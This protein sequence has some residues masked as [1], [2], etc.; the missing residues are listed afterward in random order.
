MTELLFFL[1]AVIYNAAAI[2]LV[3]LGMLVSVRFTGFAD[4][5]VDG[6]YTLSA[7]LFCLMILYTENFWISMAVAAVTGALTG[8]ATGFVNQV[9][10]VG[11][12]ISGVIIMILAVLVSPWIVGSSSL[13]IISITGIFGVPWSDL[14]LSKSLFPDATYIIH[15]IE[16]S[17]QIICILATVIGLL[18]FLR[19]KPGVRLRYAGSAETPV[20]LTPA[21]KTLLTIAGLSLGNALVGMGAA[22]EATKIGLYH[23]NIGT[24]IIL[25]ALSVLILGESIGRAI[26]RRRIL[27][28]TES[29]VGVVF[30][31]LI[32]SCGIQ[33]I[34]KFIPGS[35]DLRVLSTLLLLLLLG[36][37]SARHRNSEGLF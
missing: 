15:P 27:S 12:I 34:L 32:Y 22:L 9:L 10:G 29:I 37:A 11:K 6:S 20:L 33:L 13:S 23:Q 24:G 3:G 35:I 1:D 16:I 2:C 5:T 19:T 26:R 17:V 36:I 14:N 21:Q 25:V 31:S 7:A 4:L 8:M 18:W 28:V 30:A